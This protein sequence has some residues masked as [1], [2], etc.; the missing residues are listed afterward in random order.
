MQ[1]QTNNNET[2]AIKEQGT[3][4]SIAGVAKGVENIRELDYSISDKEGVKLPVSYFSAKCKTKA[5]T[6]LYNITRVLNTNDT[7]DIDF[8]LGGT[9]N[10]ELKP[11]CS[12]FCDNIIVYFIISEDIIKHNKTLTN[13]IKCK[14]TNDDQQEEDKEES[15]KEDRQLNRVLK[16]IAPFLANNTEHIKE[17]FNKFDIPINKTNIKP[18]SFKVDKGNIKQFIKVSLPDAPLDKILNIVCSKEIIKEFNNNG[19]FINDID[20]TQDYSGT[21]NKKDV[22]DYLLNKPDFRKE[23]DTC[24]TLDE[25]TSDTTDEL[26]DYGDLINEEIYNEEELNRINSR[27]STNKPI[28]TIIDNNNSVGANCLTFITNSYFGAVRY[29]FYNKFVQSMESP[30]VRGRVGN[31]YSHWTNNPEQI[32][33]ESINKSLDTGLLRLEITYYIEN[34]AITEEYINEHFDYLVSLLPPRLIFYN[35]ISKQWMLLLGA[36]KYNL[37]IVDVDNSL[38]MFSYSINKLTNKISGFYIKNTTTNKLSNILKLY[39]FNCPIVLLSFKRTIEEGKDKLLIKQRTYKKELI[40]TVNKSF[41]LNELITYLSNGNT[42]FTPCIAKDNSKAEDVGLIDCPI[43]RLRFQTKKN[44]SQLTTYNVPIVFKPIDKQLIEYPQENINRTTKRIKEDKEEKRFKDAREELINEII[45]ENHI[46]RQLAKEQTQMLEDKRNELIKQKEEEFNQQ[47][48]EYKA[49]EEATKIKNTFIK[50][51]NE[52]LNSNKHK[53]IELNDKEHLFVYAF[54]F[55][56]TRFGSTALLLC[57]KQDNIDRESNLSIYWAVKSVYDYLIENNNKWSELA[58]NIYGYSFGIPIIEIEKE[59]VYYNASRNLCA[60]I[61]VV[62]NTTTSNEIHLNQPLEYWHN[63]DIETI[64]KEVPNDIKIDNIL[65][66]NSYCKGKHEPID[67]L[68]K[69]GD[70]IEIFNTFQYKGSYLISFRLNG[71]EQTAK[72]NRFL[73]DIIKDKESVFKVVVGV[74]KTHPISKRCCFTFIS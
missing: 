57:S 70:V 58:N 72:S 29:K 28:K 31:H 23:G 10:K 47:M 56:F 36:I 73:D 19:I 66:H 8:T 67:K 1:P 12:R 48:Q 45:R 7:A 30:S 18:T 62:N 9:N 22:I 4:A 59:G 24:N 50:L 32:L 60:K 16:E 53:L 6:L 27:Y 43:C 39:S 41:V 65:T 69:Q 64:K 61:N 20:I 13:Y 25:Y 15:N 42:Y 11:L 35:S 44:I 40:N 68:V 71:K 52:T 5:E 38:A 3:I 34:Q 26:E 2:Q 49:Y 74:Q 14:E 21:I 46:K 51:F 63:V 54:K 17:L 37:C 33:K 55:I